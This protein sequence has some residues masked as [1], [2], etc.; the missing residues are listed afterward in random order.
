MSESQGDGLDLICFKTKQKL[1]TKRWL[2]PT[3]GRS[4]PQIRSPPWPFSLAPGMNEPFLPGSVVLLRLAKRRSL[5]QALGSGA[6]YSPVGMGFALT[7]FPSWQSLGVSL[8]PA[9]G[10]THLPYF[11]ALGLLKDAHHFLH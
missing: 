7:L 9:K 11:D 4:F 10:M 6:V 8:T 5:L 1:C 2:C 3:C